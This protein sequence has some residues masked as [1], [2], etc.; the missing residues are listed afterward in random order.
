MRAIQTVANSLK[1]QEPEVDAMDYKCGSPHDS[2]GAEEMEV[3]VSKTRAKAVRQAQRCFPTGSGGE[4]KKKKKALSTL[5]KNL[6]RNPTWFQ[7][8]K[9]SQPAGRS[10][11]PL[12]CLPTSVWGHQAI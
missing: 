4:K 2:T 9:L 1:N 10:W 5:F 3:A 11:L 7:G 6:R 12:R 8:W